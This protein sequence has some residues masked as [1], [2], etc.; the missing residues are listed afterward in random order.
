MKT[1]NHIIKEILNLSSTLTTL[2]NSNQ[3]MPE[4]IPVRV[5]TKIQ[6]DIHR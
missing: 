2:Q 4:L 6:P 1:I 3:K 5:V